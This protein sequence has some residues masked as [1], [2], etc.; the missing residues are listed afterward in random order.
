MWCKSLF[1]LTP[2]FP[3]SKFNIVLQ[4]LGK[5][6]MMLLDK[7][8]A[9][10]HKLFFSWEGRKIKWFNGIGT[11]CFSL[12]RA[13]MGRHIVS[14]AKRNLGSSF[15]SSCFCFCRCCRHQSSTCPVGSSLSEHHDCLYVSRWVNSIYGETQIFYKTEWQLSLG[16]LGF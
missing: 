3:Q 6:R 14:K 11:A 9:Q 2:G 1:L 5:G 15:T 8:Q 12:G 7:F 13:A 16:L 10:L 4:S